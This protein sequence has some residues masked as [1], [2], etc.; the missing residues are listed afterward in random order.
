M[1]FVK[2]T[3]SGE[4]L[5]ALGR[6]CIIYLFVAVFWSLWDQLDSAWV[7][8]AKKM[9]LHWL[10]FNWLPSQIVLVNPLFIMILIP[11]FSYAIYP[12]I[13][14]VFGLTPLRKI[15]IGL[16]VTASTFVLSAW[17]ETRITAGETP[18]VGWLILNHMILAAAEVMVSITCLEFS[19]TQAP[20]KMKSFIQAVFL[21][22]VSLGNAFT[23][24]VNKFIQNPDGSSKLAGASY[25]WFFTIAM[26]VTAMGFIFVAATYH[27]RTYIQDE[28][29]E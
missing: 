13:N 10:G 20:K 9:G 27:E 18:S 7:L 17:I 22:S 24:M 11:V 23:A 12:V 2:E 3:L 8:Q 1:K 6:L 15:S 16:F 28:A 5:R 21:L 25:F 14:K 29:A 19:Y 26:L 4:G